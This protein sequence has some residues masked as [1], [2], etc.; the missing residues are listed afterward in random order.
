MDLYVNRR[1]GQTG[2]SN[3]D[4]TGAGD[5]Q[6]LRHQMY[7]PLMA[8]LFE[9]TAVGLMLLDEAGAVLTMNGAALNDFGYDRA[10]LVGVEIGM[11]APGLSPN[12]FAAV[13]ERRRRV[14]GEEHVRVEFD[15][16]A[17]RR[18]GS[19][20]LAQLGVS[21]F[22]HGDELYYLCSCQ[23]TTQRREH[24]SLVGRLARHDRPTGCLNRF[25]VED[26]LDEVIETTPQS[27]LA[28]VYL[29][30]N[31]L[32]GMSE[33]HSKRL[34]ES[35]VLQAVTRLRGVLAEQD[36]LARVGR[37]E[38][39]AVIALGEGAPSATTRA[40]ELARCLQEPL[41]AESWRVPVR[42]SIGIS[43]Y[44]D[45]ARTPEG[46]IEC[47]ETAMRHAKRMESP[48]PQWYTFEDERREEDRYQRLEQIRDAVERDELAL[49]Y[50][51]QFDLS[52]LQMTGMEALLRWQHPEHGLLAPG[53]FLP[54]LVA[55][56]L[57][58]TVSRWV[59]REAVAMNTRLAAARILPVPVPVAV[60]M[61]A[62]AF[63][64][65]GFV[66]F[67]HEVLA[68]HHMPAERLEVEITETTAVTDPEQVGVNAR[69]LRALGVGVGIDDF[70][71]GFS[72]L[73]RLR[74]A[75]FSTLKI[76]RTFVSLLPG[77]ARDQSLITGL[78]DLAGG[79]NMH[80]IAEGIETRGQLE[81]LR[82]LG[83]RSGQGFWYA[84]PMPEGD[85]CAW[86]RARSEG[87]VDVT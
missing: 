29:D 28:V 2:G 49:H 10:D 45:H 6:R 82:V 31:G 83:C 37:T 87:G 36:K 13:L 21:Q 47:A 78:L 51:P 1:T 25:G 12:G 66:D 71:T 80:T 63:E 81:S 73:Q 79:L 18:D 69:A 75:N 38:L 61:G 34:K 77:G 15:V 54:L 62:R 16:E 44:P 55:S 40:H 14:A 84:R 68:E 42:S 8:S 27:R 3:S 11:L 53:Q 43:L 24:R 39:V 26:H 9:S 70:G 76:D 4:R 56:G 5:P 48:Q 60:N 46:L 57:M 33:S 52:T 64:D 86:I 7:A 41:E 23:D 58:P 74:L 22:A 59:L 67:V 20:F 85:L 72:S 50:Q 65:P 19:T 30:L 17:V 35:L 32:L